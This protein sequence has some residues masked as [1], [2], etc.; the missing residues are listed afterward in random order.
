M[1]NISSYT[2]VNPM[3]RT[4]EI[5]SELSEVAEGNFDNTFISERI[6]I[7]GKVEGWESEIDEVDIDN[8]ETDGYDSIETLIFE[9]KNTLCVPETSDEIIE[10]IITQT[11]VINSAASILEEANL[12]DEIA[13]TDLT[14]SVPELFD[15]FELQIFDY[16]D[17]EFV[18]SLI[19]LTDKHWKGK[20]SVRQ[21]YEDFGV[22]PILNLALNAMGEGVCPEDNPQVAVKLQL[23]GIETPDFILELPMEFSCENLEYDLKKAFA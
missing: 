13:R 4:E 10:E 17:Q 19:Q 12:F 5:I 11:T 20:Y 9:A 6:E 15:R 16:E 1:Y 2:K 14:E 21:L 8:L 23:L 22:P 18:G 7:L 3:K